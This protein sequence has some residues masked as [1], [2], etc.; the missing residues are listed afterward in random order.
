MRQHLSG[1]RI[2]RPCCIVDADELIL[3][4][5]LVG[6]CDVPVGRLCVI[7]CCA[8]WLAQGRELRPAKGTYPAQA[9]EK[10]TKW[11]SP[12]I[13]VLFHVCRLIR[14]RSLKPS[15]DSSLMANCVVCLME[16]S[17][18]TVTN[19]HHQQDPAAEPEHLIAAASPVAQ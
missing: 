7:R 12:S 14:C 18:L 11:S 1:L 2:G 3:G 4:A 8:L 16:T 6:G 13:D 19:V 5:V 10:S 9:L 15:A 17:A